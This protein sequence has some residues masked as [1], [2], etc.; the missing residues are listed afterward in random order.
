[1]DQAV[2]AAPMRQKPRA[3]DTVSGVMKNATQLLQRP[4]NLGTMIT[5]LL[6]CLLLAVGWLAA[7]QLLA[8]PVTM[9]QRSVTSFGAYL[10]LEVLYWLLSGVLLTV[11]VLPAL[12]GRI[13]LAGMLA[14]GA[15]PDL[16]ELLYY[17]TSWRRLGRAVIT[18]L[19][20][21]LE[22]M[23]P[24]TVGLGLAVGSF[25]LYE[26]VFWEVFFNEWVAQLCLV[27]CLLL[28]LLPTLITA[29][30]TGMLALSTAF[31]V[32]NEQ[33]P[34]TRC[35]ALSWRRSIR[36]IGTL[37]L[38]AL[39]TV[40]HLLLSLCTIGVLHLLWYGHHNIISYLCLAMALDQGD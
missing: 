33:L 4:G 35:V 13:R 6:F 36:R 20:A 24:V 32:G 23:I 3:A 29:L 16:G 25:A 21:F 18:A 22:L 14:M 9:L 11:S 27:L 38:F 39:R 15:Y 31:A 28:S 40:W 8:I 10:L 7:M 17:Y 12:L 26:Y 34:L 30:L 37:L 2:T 5:S 1:M 19:I